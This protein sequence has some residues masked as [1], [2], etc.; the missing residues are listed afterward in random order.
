MQ[1]PLGSPLGSIIKP[2]GTKYRGSTETWSITFDDTLKAR[3][4]TAGYVSDR[5]EENTTTDGVGLTFG[6]LKTLGVNLPSVAGNPLLQFIQ[7]TSGPLVNL[8]IAP[9]SM[10]SAEDVPKWWKSEKRGAEL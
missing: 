7:A 6:L 9:K 8:G 4:M 1:G 10:S 3:L 5:F 2:D